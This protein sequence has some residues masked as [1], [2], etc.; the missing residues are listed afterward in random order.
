MEKTMK[1][2]RYKKGWDKLKEIDG[3]AGENV[4]NALREP[5]VLN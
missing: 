2:E 5:Q 1:S 3:V 4:I